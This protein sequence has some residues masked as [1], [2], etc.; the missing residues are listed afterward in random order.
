MNFLK[1]LM[2]LSKQ[3]VCSSASGSDTDNFDKGYIDEENSHDSHDSR[4]GDSD[5]TIS[6]DEN[7]NVHI[8]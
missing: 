7:D 6:N 8:Q 5:H 3:D 4:K 1:K 2:K